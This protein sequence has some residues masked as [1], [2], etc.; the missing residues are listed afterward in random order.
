M[1]LR[2]ER[3][4]DGD[5]DIIPGTDVGRPVTNIISPGA[6]AYIPVDFAYSPGDFVSSPGTSYVRPEADGNIPWNNQ[7]NDIY[8]HF[9]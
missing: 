1:V 9:S 3:L 6:I 4:T 7:I 2:N 8:N 5:I